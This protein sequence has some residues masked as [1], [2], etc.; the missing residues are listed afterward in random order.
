MKASI[1]IDGSIPSAVL[2]TQLLREGFEISALSIKTGNENPKSLAVIKAISDHYEIGISEIDAANIAYMFENKLTGQLQSATFLI[3]MGM[4]N[5][6]DIYSHEY[7]ESPTAIFPATIAKSIF[8]MSDKTM[9]LNTP[10]L[11]MTFDLIIKVGSQFGVP[12]ELTWSCDETETDIQCG[13]CEGCKARYEAFKKAG[14]KDPLP[15]DIV[16]IHEMAHMDDKRPTE[17]LP[18]TEILRSP[19]LEEAGTEA[20]TAT[21]VEPHVE[22][23]AP[24]PTPVP[25]EEVSEAAK[26]ATKIMSPPKSSPEIVQEPEAPRAITPAS[27]PDPIKDSGSNVPL[28]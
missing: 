26:V 9:R 8:L 19:T 23:P 5:G 16:E 20:A 18:E 21:R 15:M 1:I 11:R 28:P 13:K 27:N 12:F 10:F 2:L 4:Q 22:I 14:V 17:I 25:T 24:E 6:G 7:R 3:A